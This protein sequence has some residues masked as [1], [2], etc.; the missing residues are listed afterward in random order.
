MTDHEWE[1]LMNSL[2]DIKDDVG[3]IKKE[4]S[5]LKVKV[6]G[7]AAFIGAVFSSLFK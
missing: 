3:E 7:F 4:M 2:K 6:A 5:S 1:L